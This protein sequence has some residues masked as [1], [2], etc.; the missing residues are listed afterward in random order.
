MFGKNA[1][2]LERWIDFY[3]KFIKQLAYTFFVQKRLYRVI[4]LPYKKYLLV[5]ILRV[6]IQLNTVAVLR[7]SSYIMVVWVS[8][9]L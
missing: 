8:Y 7:Y 5:L 1:V 6:N 2:L 3:S 4:I 9:K